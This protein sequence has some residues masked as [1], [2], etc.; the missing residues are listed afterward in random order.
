MSNS[1]ALQALAAWRESKIRTT[2]LPASGLTV[3]YKPVD[4]MEL[5]STGE[6]PDGMK[7]FLE[8]KKEGGQAT[9]KVSMQMEELPQVATAFD[10]IARACLVEALIDGTAVPFAAVG[11]DEH[12][13]VNELPFTDK[14]HLFELS[15]EGLAKIAPFRGEQE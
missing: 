13:G 7:Q 12:I 11:D 10:G 14:V 6:I 3:R 5:A 4:L 15:N 9:G 1:G 2:E 8:A